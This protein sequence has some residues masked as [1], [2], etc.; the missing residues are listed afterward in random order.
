MLFDILI[1][2]SN[3]PAEIFNKS[4]RW[5]SIDG[6]VSTNPVCVVWNNTL[7]TVLQL[8]LC[9]YIC[10]ILFENYSDTMAITNRSIALNQ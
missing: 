2:Q 10:Y 6:F 7:L 5:L 4:N 3:F 8:G 1:G 9:L